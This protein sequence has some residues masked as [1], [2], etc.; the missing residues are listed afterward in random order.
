M[1]YIK[2]IS[3]TSNPFFNH[4]RAFEDFLNNLNGEIV[5]VSHAVTREFNE[6]HYSAIITYKKP[7]KKEN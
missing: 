2:H 5:Q 3:G 7:T 4:L 6:P 1:I